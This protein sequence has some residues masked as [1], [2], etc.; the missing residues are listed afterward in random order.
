MKILFISDLHLNKGLVRKSVDLAKK[1]KVEVIVNNGDYLSNSFANFFFKEGKDFKIFTVNGNWDGNL[2]S[3]S[4]NA[5][6]L[7]NE[8]EEF[9]GFYFMGVDEGSFYEDELYDLSEGI[10]MEK[11]IVL[12]HYPPYKTKDKMWNGM[13]IGF[14]EYRRFIE[15]KEPLIF[16]C[17]HIHEDNGYIFLKKTLVVNSA[18][19]AMPYAYVV[20]IVKGRDIKIKKVKL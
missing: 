10:D 17:G 16:S 9:R 12:G 2:V 8:I 15:K 3:E 4:R 18:L 5:V 20:D 1:E 11:L 14:K 6:V 7:N 13:H 19:I